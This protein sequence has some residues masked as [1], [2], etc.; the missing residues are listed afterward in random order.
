VFCPRAGG[1]QR[2]VRDDRIVDERAP[3]DGIR[4]HREVIG[5]LSDDELTA[6]IEGL[7]PLPDADDDDPAWL[8]DATCDRAEFLL[9]AADA[10]GE[11]RLLRA[12]ARCSSG[13]RSATVTK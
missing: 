4:R 5:P 3:A 11:R 12:I 2:D 10:I 6:R 8:E 1:P 13:P 9:A 7:K